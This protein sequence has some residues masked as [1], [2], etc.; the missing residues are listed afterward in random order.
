[1]RL[2]HA[3]IEVRTL[4]TAL[5]VSCTATWAAGQL[6]LWRDY[7]TADGDPGLSVEDMQ[8]RF[9]GRTASLFEARVRGEMRPYLQNGEEMAE[10]TAWAATGADR[11]TYDSRVAPVLEK[12]CT[13]CHKPAGQASFR[14]LTTFEEV[15]ECVDAPPAPPLAR[16]LL[17]TKVHLAG[18]G[19]LLRRCGRRSSPPRSRV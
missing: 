15:R 8:V 14:P 16:Q 9:T 17:V 4:I 6:L 13:M 12:R 10:L 18:I 11:L 7:A 2:R 5:L 19:L 1:M 3:P